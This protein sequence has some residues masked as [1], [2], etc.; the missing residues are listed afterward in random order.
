MTTIAFIGLGNMGGPMA[1][2]LATAGHEVRGYDVV[3]EACD[4]AR[5]NGITVCADPA[6][7]ADGA[8]VIITS[9]PNGGLVSQVLTP[10]FAPDLLFI[11]CSTI[12]VDEARTLADAASAAGARFLDAPVSGG[13]AGAAAGT[14][15]FMVGGDEAAFAE[16]TPLLDVM[17]RSVTHCGATGTG[18]AVKACNNMILAVQQIALSEALVLGERLG[19][20]HQAFY[21]VVANATGSSWSLTVNA[22]VPDVVP[23]PPANNEF[24][25]GFASALML[26]DLKLAMAAAESTGTDTVL[27]RIAA[28]QYAA[29]VDEG[30]GGLDFSAIINEVRG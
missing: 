3:P 20:S 21:D 14:L 8:T 26:K 12:A 23:T 22:P 30:N 15:A 10:L 24:K 13:I 11:D 2:N 19:L 16:A 7:A 28:E 29:F 27:G 6:E 17:G 4:R 18:Q 1:A 5:Q 25:P 9:L